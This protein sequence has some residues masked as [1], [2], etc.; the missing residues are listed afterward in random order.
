MDIEID[1]PPLVLEELLFRLGG[2]SFS[3][4]RGKIQ[5]ALD[6]GTL[7]NVSKTEAQ[8]M[9]AQIQESLRILSDP[10]FQSDPHITYQKQSLEVGNDRLRQV[11]SALVMVAKLLGH[12]SGR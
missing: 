11:S 8:T 9:R 12:G 6:E 5:K 3:V 7:L 1:L 10:S 2:K 4:L